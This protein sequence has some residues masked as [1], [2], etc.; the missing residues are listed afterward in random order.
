MLVVNIAPNPMESHALSPWWC[1]SQARPGSGRAIKQILNPHQG[2]QHPQHH[3]QE[4][5]LIG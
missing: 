2:E 5:A 1:R 4:Q 3:R